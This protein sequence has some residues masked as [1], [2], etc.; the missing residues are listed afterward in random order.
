LK[1]KFKET[2]KKQL[3]LSLIKLELGLV[4]CEELGF[5]MTIGIES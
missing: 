1:E 3:S 4:G 2:K 5:L